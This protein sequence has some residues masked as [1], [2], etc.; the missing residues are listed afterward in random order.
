MKTFDIIQLEF[1]DLVKGF[2][3]KN[4]NMPK[5]FCLNVYKHIKQHKKKAIYLRK[6]HVAGVVGRHSILL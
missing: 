5:T 3:C 4:P 6:L 2:L 1:I